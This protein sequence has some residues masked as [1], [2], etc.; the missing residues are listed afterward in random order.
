MSDDLKAPFPYFGGSSP[1]AGEVWDA[2][3]D[4][5]H[6]IEPFAGSCAVLLQRPSWHTHFVE[7]VNDADCLLANVW[8]GLKNKPD[9]CAAYADSPVNHCC[10]AGTKVSSPNGDIDIERVRPGMIVYGVK[11]G[12]LVTTV[13]TAIQN[14]KS[15]TLFSLGALQATGNHPVLTRNGFVR[16]DS[17]ESGDEVLELYWGVNKIDPHGNRLE[18]LRIDRSENEQGALR[19]RIVKG[20]NSAE[21]A[22][23]AG[24]N[25]NQGNSS[26]LLDCQFTTRRSD[27]RND[28]FGGCDGINMAGSRAIL[29]CPLSE[30][31]EVNE[32]HRRRGWVRGLAGDTGAAPQAIRKDEGKVLPRVHDARKASQPR[33]KGK[34][35]G[36][37][38][39]S[40]YATTRSGGSYE[41]TS[42]VVR[43]AQGSIAKGS[44]G[45]DLEPGAQSEDRGCDHQQEARDS[46]RGWGRFSFKD[47]S[48]KS[49]DG[50]RG[51][52]HAGNSEAL[53]IQRIPLAVPVTVYNFE[54]E[55]HNYFADS[56]LV[57]NCDLMARKKWLIANKDRI[58]AGLLSDPEWSD[59]QAAGYWIWAASCWIGSGM[60]CPNQ[61]PHVSHGGMGIHAMG[62]RPHVSHGGMGAPFN[63]NIYTTFR[64][65]Q[66]R[67][68]FVRVVCGD[69]TQVSGGD[70]QTKIGTCGYFAD[71]PYSKEA[72]RDEC[73][74]DQ[75]SLT[76]AHDVREWMKAR[77]NDPQMRM[78]I[79]GYYQEHEELVARGW[80]VHRWTARGGY[81]NIAGAGGGNSRGQD[82]RFKEALF[83]SPH[84][85]NQ[86][87]SLFGAGA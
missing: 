68:R 63:P 2:L 19:W 17:L 86:N 46:R 75:D 58:K 3:G 31:R 27:S 43:G 39:G 33:I 7:T 42:S 85:L 38:S 60:T 74:Y 50:V 32:C 87:Q 59:P 4:C 12:Q 66:D 67:L 70:W 9:E 34:N 83:F 57:H 13:V 18:D 36:R 29:D 23:V 64:R 30:D 10:P 11:D 40:S 37:R 5:S 1:I 44:Y 6:Y 76:V 41:V 78:V 56:I 14:T 24:E 69:W 80:R 49:D 77:E 54:T 82:N 47:R 81:A 22:P 48:G 79:K 52:Y 25:G 51:V 55:S 84:C 20:Q 72:D 62:K 15:D 45:K 8:R 65:L 26:G 61:R 28:D 53:P 73:I 35:I 21:Y 71:P 16:M